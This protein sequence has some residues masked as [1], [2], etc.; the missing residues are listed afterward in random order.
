LQYTFTYQDI[1]NEENGGI[2]TISDFESGDANYDNRQRLEVYF[3]DAESFLKARGYS[4]ITFPV[5]P[6]KG[7]TIYTLAI[8]LITRINF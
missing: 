8:N 1:L 5:N 7:I 2:T 6:K 3:N 4:W